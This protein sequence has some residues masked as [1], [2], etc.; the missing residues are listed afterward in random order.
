MCD[1]LNLSRSGYYAWEKARESKN[2]TLNKALIPEIRRI[3]SE[4]RG[5]YGSPTICAALRQEGF[6]VNH[7]RIARLM[8]G[9]GLRSKVVKRFKRTTQPCKSRD[10]SPNLLQQDFQTDGPNRVWLSDIT[11]IR[12]DEGWVYLTTIEDMWSRRLVGHAITDHLCATAVIEALKLALG[13][14][15]VKPGLIFHSDRGKQ[16]SD[17]QVRK[18]F[19]EYGIRQSMSSTGNCYD[20]AMA[21]SFFATMKKGHVFWRRFQTR[22]QARRII[23]EYVE[24]FYNR[25]RRHSSLGY[26]SPVAFEQQI[27]IL[28]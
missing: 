22:D 24:I 1:L 26:R 6:L 16:Y 23:F 12:T 14:R 27:D 13:R 7:K 18:V 20:N 19:A 10:A 2:A 11:F 25:I 8:R 28:A 5:E 17:G 9:I 3:Y 4:G 21:E 15:S